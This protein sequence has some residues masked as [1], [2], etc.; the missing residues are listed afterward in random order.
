MHAASPKPVRVL[1][2]ATILV[3]FALACLAFASAAPPEP[4]RCHG[5]SADVTEPSPYVA[6][7]VT[8]VEVEPE[9]VF[10]S[11]PEPLPMRETVEGRDPFATP[12]A[13]YP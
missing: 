5:P 2:P 1:H 11:E 3:L 6:V 7:P 9:F 13:F 4:T 10:D 12:T 8:L